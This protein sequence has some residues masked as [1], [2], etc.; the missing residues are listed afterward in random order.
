LDGL[1][2][3]R[4]FLVR[5]TQVKKNSRNRALYQNNTQLLCLHLQ[6]RT[7]L[8]HQP[9]GLVA[10]GSSYWLFE[11]P[12]L[13]FHSPGRTLQT[14]FSCVG[15]LWSLW[16]C[17]KKLLARPLM[18]IR[19]CP[20]SGEKD[21]ILVRSGPVRRSSLCASATMEISNVASATTT[22]LSLTLLTSLRSHRQIRYLSIYCT[23]RHLRRLPRWFE[24]RE[25]STC[26]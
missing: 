17:I 26:D 18:C 16:S 12:I 10:E 8:M 1:G 15:C 11:S 25:L 13:S 6:P 20:G 23:A 19:T 2:S 24:G 14:S 22:V 4:F 21:V 7:L 3:V 9:V 5:N